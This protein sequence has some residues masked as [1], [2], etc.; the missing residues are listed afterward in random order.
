MKKL[1]VVAILLAVA[2]FI[3]G[4]Y[5]KRS[6][7]ARIKTIS[8]AGESVALDKHMVKG[9]VTIFDFYADWCGP[10]R[11]LAP[12]LESFVQET[13]NVYLR[14]INIKK[15][16]S[17]VAKKYEIHSVPSIWIYDKRG[18]LGQKTGSSMKTIRKEV[19]SLL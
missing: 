16:G 9:G 5:A 8:R 11:R 18:R 1:V 19:L 6:D 7:T 12:K 17:P 4:E 15:W 14:K 10:C 2:Y 13:P 3:Y